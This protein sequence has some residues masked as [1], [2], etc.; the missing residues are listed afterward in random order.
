[1]A[2]VVGRTRE[3]VRLTVGLVGLFTGAPESTLRANCWVRS[4]NKLAWQYH[5]QHSVR[6]DDRYHF[7]GVY[8]CIVRRIDKLF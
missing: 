6:P 2:S 7:W 4:A 5:F 1:M 3:A 8:K